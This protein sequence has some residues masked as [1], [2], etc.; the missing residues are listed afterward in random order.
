MNLKLNLFEEYMNHYR[1]FNN[2]L[3]YYSTPFWYAF[4]YFQNSINDSY[5]IWNNISKFDY[6]ERSILSAPDEEQINLINQEK[7]IVINEIEI[8]KPD[9]CIFFIGKG[10]KYK[11]ILDILFDDY[12][13]IELENAKMKMS[14]FGRESEKYT[15]SKIKSKYLPEKSFI[16]YHP[17]TI[18]WQGVEIRDN[19]YDLLKELIV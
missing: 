13:E 4:N 16:T 12:N 10:Y 14:F 11:W 7:N 2:G 18:N 6:Q 1:N 17:N 5:V 3:G 8:L 9:I 15:I 19:I